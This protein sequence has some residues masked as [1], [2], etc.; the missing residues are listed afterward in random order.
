MNAALKPLVLI[1]ED[2]ADILT[3]LK[4]NLEKEGFRVATASDGEEALLAAGE[5]TPHIVLLDWMLPLMSGLEVCRQLRR[6][7]KTRDIPIIMLTARGEEGDRVRGLNSGAD[8]Y[9]TKPFSPT[10]LVA[11]MRAVLRRA[12]PGMTDEVLTFADVTMDLAAHRVR[13]NGRDVHLG[14]TEFRLLRHFMQHAG[15]V[16]SREQLLDLVWGHDVYVEPRTVDVHIRRLRKAMNEED[17]LDL[18][19]TVRSA[20]YALDTKSV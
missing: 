1:V 18:I 12:S 7:A 10:E 9:I 13:R 4:Y 19:R 5:Q 20:G 6:N 3:L 16:F 14:P 8:D 2:E 11:R 17:E 15:R